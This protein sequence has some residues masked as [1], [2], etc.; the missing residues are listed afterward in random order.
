MR[1]TSSLTITS[2]NEIPWSKPS[3]GDDEPLQLITKTLNKE[4]SE[5][6]RTRKNIPC[7]QIEKL[8]L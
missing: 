8:I 1:E 2:E 3:L 4:I 7:S 6:T 5:G